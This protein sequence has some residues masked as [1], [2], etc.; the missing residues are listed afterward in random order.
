MCRWSSGA[1]SK[2]EDSFVEKG[3][4]RSQLARSRE[5]NCVS[6][7]SFTGRDTLK[8]VREVAGNDSM[9]FS[10]IASETTNGLGG[11]DFDGKAF[12]STILDVIVEETVEGKSGRRS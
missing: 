9:A 3:S 6:R 4:N 8:S 7:A 2:K 11:V 10:L 5:S 12:C 1:S